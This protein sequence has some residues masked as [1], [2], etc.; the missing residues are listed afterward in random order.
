MDFL[1]K[2][3]TVF[4]HVTP[5]GR[6]SFFLLFFFLFFFI[7]YFPPS[8]QMH[9]DVLVKEN[10]LQ[11]SSFCL[12]VRKQSPSSAAKTSQR[13]CVFSNLKNY[14]TYLAVTE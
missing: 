2:S 9:S 6:Q 3:G 8:K 14:K 11:I 5:Q 4:P 10:I 12:Q 13:K 7:F 1:M